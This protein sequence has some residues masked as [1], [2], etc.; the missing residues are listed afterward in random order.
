MTL[1]FP[2]KLKYALMARKLHT[3]NNKYLISIIYK[4]ILYH[5]STK[6]LVWRLT[7][8]KW[9]MEFQY[10]RQTDLCVDIAPLVILVDVGLVERTLV[11]LE[12]GALSSLRSRGLSDTVESAA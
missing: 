2:E 1:K 10:G 3:S 9:P 7:K 12:D 6:S 8:I 5:I 4:L 11:I